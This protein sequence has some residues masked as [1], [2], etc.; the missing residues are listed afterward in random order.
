MGCRLN[1]PAD[2]YTTNTAR[3]P[4]R[5]VIGPFF[6]SPPI[7]LVAEN[8]HFDAGNERAPLLACSHQTD[9]SPGLRIAYTGRNSR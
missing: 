6:F 7:P 4:V 5:S 9:G 1:R 3:G 8:E 2:L